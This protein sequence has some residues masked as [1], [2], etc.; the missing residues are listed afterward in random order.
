ML[1][2]TVGLRHCHGPWLW[3]LYLS[4]ASGLLCCFRLCRSLHSPESSPTD[5]GITASAL[6]WISSFLAVRSHSVKLSG[7]SS[8]IFYVLLGVPRGSILGPL[9]FILYTL[10]IVNIASQHGLVVHLYADDTQLYIKL[11]CKHLENIKVKMAACIHHIQSWCASMR[12]KLSATKTEL[13]WFDRRSRVDDNT[14][15]HLNLDPQCSIPPSDVVRDFGVL[16]DCKL[17][18]TQHV[19]STARTCFFHLRRIRQV[20]RYLDETCRRILVQARHL[21]TGL[22]QLCPLGPAFIHATTL[23]LGTTYCCSSNKR[24]QS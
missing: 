24:S 10:N 9:L 5:F 8:K 18:M 17:N 12:F 21:P 20:R 7:S 22:L 13:I 14:T 11:C 1:L 16:L 2:Q 6:Q 3:L 15:M 19:S 23:I 4:A